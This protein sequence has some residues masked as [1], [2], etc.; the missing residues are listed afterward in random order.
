MNRRDITFTLALVR[1]GIFI[2]VALAVTGLL[3]VIM[4]GIGLGSQREY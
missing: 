4:C 1:L 2:V 3:V